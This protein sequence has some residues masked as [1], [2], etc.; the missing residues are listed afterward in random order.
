MSWYVIQTRVREEL[1]VLENL[2]AQ[3][4]YVFSRAYQI[5]KNQGKILL[6]T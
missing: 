5:G 3:N 2:Q 1:G 4:F 6:A